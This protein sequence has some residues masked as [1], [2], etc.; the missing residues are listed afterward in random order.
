M[1]RLSAVPAIPAINAAGLERG[2][3]AVVGFSR[4]RARRR[5]RKRCRRSDRIGDRLERVETDAAPLRRLRED[6][7]D[8]LGA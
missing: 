2:R 6:E 1:P 8:L 3:A 4:I 7:L 5:W